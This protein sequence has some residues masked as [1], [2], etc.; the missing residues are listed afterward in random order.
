MKRHDDRHTITP[1]HLMLTTLLHEAGNQ[2]HAAGSSEQ[3]APEP[4]TI[5]VYPVEG[6]GLLFSRV[7]LEPEEDLPSTPPIIE[8]DQPLGGPLPLAGGKAPP[9]F[10]VFVLLLGV[11]LLLDSLDATLTA[12]LTP[13]VTITLIP[14]TQTVIT[15]MTVYLGEGPSQLAGHVLPSL[16]VTQ[17]R[18]NRATGHGHQDAT[19][20]T[21][22][23]TVYNGLFTAYTLPAGTV[24]TGGDGVRV[25]TDATLTVPAARPPQF[26]QASVSAT[27]L[28][29]GQVGNIAAD[30]I[31]TTLADGILVQN[32]LFGGGQDARDFPLVTQADIQAGVSR[33]TLQLVQSARAALTAQLRTGEA[34]LT[35]TCTPTVTTD[36]KAGREAVA[37][38]VT[39]AET[40]QA[41]AYVSQALIRQ[42]SRLVAMQAR[43]TLGPEYERTGSVQVTDL[44][45][46]LPPTTSEVVVSFTGQASYVYQFS[47]P[48]QQRIKRLVAGQS[49]RAALHLLSAL[50][51]VAQVHLSGVADNGQVPADVTHIHLLLIWSGS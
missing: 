44:H 37:V 3:Q 40:C 7:P 39:V 17:S 29:A 6:G 30:D 18:T 49:R 25:V 15:G 10:L 43:H 32:G 8:S 14:R 12:W 42:V 35:P 9:V 38:Q 13:T 1:G 34:L 36:Q 45:A 27:A 50:P 31:H 46:S 47:A 2:T 24:V 11:F 23:L 21:G 20:A 4:E 26:G 28:L 33:L 16:T 51:G 22:L 41:I 19:H 5:H 48:A